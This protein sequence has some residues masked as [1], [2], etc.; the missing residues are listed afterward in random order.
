MTKNKILVNSRRSLMQNLMYHQNLFLITECHRSERGQIK[1]IKHL[2][3]AD[4]N[5]DGIFTSNRFSNLGF[6]VHWGEV[7]WGM[8]ARGQ[9]G[10]FKAGFL[11]ITI[12]SHCGEKIPQIFFFQK[13]LLTIIAFV[14]PFCNAMSWDAGEG[15]WG[16]FGRGQL[17]A[18]FG[19]CSDHQHSARREV[20]QKQPTVFFVQIAGL[21]WADHLPLSLLGG[22]Y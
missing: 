17:A 3:I 15:G 18:K 2:I 9:T 10:K 13:S 20:P 4:T 22:W 8:M 16:G 7:G 19:F 1:E 12:P 5:D 6:V 21:F 14:Y 11:R